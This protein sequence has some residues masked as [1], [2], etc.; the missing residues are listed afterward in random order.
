MKIQLQNLGLKNV[1]KMNNFRY[2]EPFQNN[3]KTNNCIKFVF[4]ARVIPKKGIEDAIKVINLINK[5][6]KNIVS[7]DIYGQCE[8]EY[9]NKLR[10]LF[11][12]HIIYHGPITP[13]GVREYEELSKY[14]ILLFPT[15]FYEEGLPGTIIDAYI[16]SLA[17]IASE[18]KYSREYICDG[19]NGYIF[20]FGD[21]DD[22]YNKTLKILDYDKISKFKLKSK[23]ISKSYDA[24]Y[25]LEKFK[26]MLLK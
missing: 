5:N 23:K 13:N 15:L 4:W 26:N 25:V 8:H 16:A 10:K 6:T 11:N 14:D 1:E 17:V 3:Y 22:F 24:S 2:I 18:W 20:K 19:E 21:F 7:L 12:D 9:L